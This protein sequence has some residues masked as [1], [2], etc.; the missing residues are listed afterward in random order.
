VEK[1]IEKSD[2]GI[3][4]EVAS[5][6]TGV[7]LK[8]VL[9]LPEIVSQVANKTIVYVGEKHDRYGDH[10]LQ[11]E[12]IR[13]LHK[14][15]SKIAIGMEMFQ[16]RYQKA[17]DDYIS[18]ESDTQTFL[19]RSR[20]FSTWRFNYHLYEDILQ[21]AK[22]N[23]IPVVALNQ[24]RE[25]VS[26]VAQEGLEQ[27]S[28]KEKDQIPEEMIFEDEPYKKRLRRV[29]EMHQNQLSRDEV[30]PV[31]EYFHQAQILW[32]ETMAESIATFLADRSDYRLVVLAGS[33]HLAYG[34]GI[35]KRAYRRTGKEYAIFEQKN[36][37]LLTMSKWLFKFKL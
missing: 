33:G 35:P 19:K 26:K 37:H 5:P 20:Y 9:N 3:R 25:L 10:L 30:P 36:S 14:K 32:D 15:H 13:E 22:A 11:L 2:R 23:K 6:V 28:P 18:G 27:L 1:E 21:Y 24:D 17:L 4:H 31:F 34:S 7:A 29:F 12:V 16:R 8:S